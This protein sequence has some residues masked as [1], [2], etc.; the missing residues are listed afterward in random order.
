MNASWMS[1][2][3][4]AVSDCF[5]YL[6]VGLHTIY[7]TAAATMRWNNIINNN[8]IERHVVGIEFIHAL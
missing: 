5:L 2:D 6:R 1:V 7:T 3:G 8:F 4:G